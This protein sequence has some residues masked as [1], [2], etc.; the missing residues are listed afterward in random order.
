ME[1]KKISRNLTLHYNTKG[2]YFIYQGLRYYIAVEKEGMDPDFISVRS[3][4]VG[5]T[6]P[7]YIHGI[8]ISRYDKFLFLSLS[9]GYDP[10]VTLYTMI[11]E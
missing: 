1:F 8:C 11:G 2:T 3:P 9:D 10:T 6:Y 5:G 4:F 7:D